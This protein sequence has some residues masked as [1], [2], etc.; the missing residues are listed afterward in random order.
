MLGSI[1]ADTAATG[2]I[3]LAQMA[4]CTG[5]SLA[6][7][8]IIA[9][10]YMHRNS[11]TKNF[12]ITIA[13]L[14]TLVQAVILLVNGNLGAGVAVMGAFSLVRFRSVP[15]SAR[16]ITSIF[17]AMAIGLATGMGYLAYAA[18]FTVVVA[19]MMVVLNMS[20]FG[21]KDKSEKLLRITVPEDLDYLHLFDDLYSAYT[22][23]AELMRVRTTDMGS[24]FELRYKV[25][26][27]DG[28]KE[29]ELIDG[30]RQRNGNLMV[31]LERMI[32]A[33]EEL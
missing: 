18:L 22:T 24:L 12:V 17:F 31:S 20:R 29:K 1:F 32:T 26:L 19:G 14:P 2:N 7:G 6:L 28:D 16:E 11:Y 8:I 27:K 13:L 25:V 4:F 23:H 3:T 9:I 33:K 21:E 5:T 30:I 10:T 15:G